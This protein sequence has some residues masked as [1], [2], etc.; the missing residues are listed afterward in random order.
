MHC[1][2]LNLHLLLPISHSGRKPELCL[3][4]HFHLRHGLKV[5]MVREEEDDEGREEAVQAFK[6]LPF[7]FVMVQYLAH[8]SGQA[9]SRL[10]I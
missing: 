8:D 1:A 2:G 3:L 4:L 5:L 6:T 10:A 9:K 7:V